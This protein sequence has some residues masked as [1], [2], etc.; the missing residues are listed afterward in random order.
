MNPLPQPPQN[1]IR[2]TINHYI[3]I[4]RFFP[5]STLYSF[6]V[7][8][9]WD[10]K[11][12]RK[13]IVTSFEED[14]NFSKYSIIYKGKPLYDDLVHLE[15]LFG[16][17]SI[18]HLQI[19]LTEQENDKNQS[20]RTRTDIF[21]S[22][23]FR[24]IEKELFS[25]YF[26]T[27]SDSNA[28]GNSNAVDYHS[29][30]FAHRNI[31]QRIEIVNSQNTLE[32]LKTFEQENIEQFPMRDYFQMETIF[33]IFIFVIL[34]LNQFREWNSPLVIASLVIYYWYVITNLLHDYYNKKIENITFTSEEI[35]EIEKEFNSKI[36]DNNN[37]RNFKYDKHNNTNQREKR[38]KL[39]QH[40]TN[41][42]VNEEEE[43]KR[44]EGITL[45]YV[46]ALLFEIVSSFFYSLLPVWYDNFELT[47]PI[48]TDSNNNNNNTN[49]NNDNSNNNNINQEDNQTSAINDNNARDN[50]NSINDSNSQQ[51][52]ETIKLKEEVKMIFSSNNSERVNVP[53]SFMMNT[54]EHRSKHYTFI[55]PNDNKTENEYIFTEN[56]NLD[57][58]SNNESLLEFKGIANENE[59]EEDKKDR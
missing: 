11:R 49:T 44:K 17:S 35:S 2:Q 48:T 59:D 52:E 42:R 32:L 16:T 4:L 1:K 57:N 41:Q 46:C 54:S 58:M 51:Q 3:I 47:N 9:H 27:I 29:F 8:T 19:L 6:H 45:R 7:P 31:V 50:K 33:K 10:I 22:R 39:E 15:E 23:E 25:S 13:F 36:N 26:A 30:P 12:L 37:E 21:K 34:F 5:N 38:E 40:D 55:R 28:I 24:E 18:N 43:E 53:S 20:N 56:C 14:I